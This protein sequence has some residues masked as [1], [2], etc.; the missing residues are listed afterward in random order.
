MLMTQRSPTALQQALHRLLDR[1]RPECDDASVAELFIPEANPNDPGRQKNFIALRLQNGSVGLSYVLHSRWREKTFADG[2]RRR[3]VGRSVIEIAASMGTAEA[4]WRVVC[5]GAF[6]AVCQ[7]VF[8]RHRANLDYA[9]DSLGQ[10][11]IDGSDRVGMV[12]FFP[13]LVD[14]VRQAGAELIVIEK[15]PALIEKYPEV[16]VSLDPAEL[17]SC[18]KILCTGTTLINNT[19]EEIL[20]RCNPRALVAVIGPTA[21]FFPDAYFESGVDILG[22]IFIKDPDRLWQLI[23]RSE[24]WG[25]A[26][27]KICFQKK[28]YPGIDAWLNG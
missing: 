10:L 16:K 13:P 18:N 12:G 3:A 7:Q 26:T 5:V 24:K 20:C 21:G 19:I 15:K 22:G 4:D 11:G 28:S 6:N 8:T 2:L 14:R 1:L 25:E 23:T 27:D 17:A 9:T